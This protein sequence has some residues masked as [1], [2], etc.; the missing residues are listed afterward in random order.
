MKAKIKIIQEY[1]ALL[2][3][4]GKVNKIKCAANVGIA[5]SSQCTTLDGKTSKPIEIADF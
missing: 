2:A 1:N 5:R 4:E 3:K